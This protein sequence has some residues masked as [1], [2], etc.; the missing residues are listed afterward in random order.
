M[1]NLSKQVQKV[2]DETYMRMIEESLDELYTCLRGPRPSGALIVTNDLAIF[3]GVFPP[4]G[5]PSCKDEGE[6]MIVDGHCV[7]NVHAEVNALL[8]CASL[9]QT[10]AG[11]T[12][13]SWNKPCYN[14]TINMIQ[15][16]VQKIV[17][18]HVVYDEE[19]T[20]NAIDASGIECYQVGV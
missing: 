13:Y 4:D 9:G 11:S 12:V 15:A 17:Y 8:N 7:R 1:S 10:T 2:Q 16:G 6:C 14:C 3:G 5:S 20:Q 18:K 19:R